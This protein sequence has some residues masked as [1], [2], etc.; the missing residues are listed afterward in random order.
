MMP[1]GPESV[2]S[3]ISCCVAYEPCTTSYLKVFRV[4]GREGARE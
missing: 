1:V 3:K 2:V 4:C